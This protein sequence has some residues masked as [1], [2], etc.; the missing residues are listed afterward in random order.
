MRTVNYIKVQ[1]RRFSIGKKYEKDD[2]EGTGHVWIQTGAAHSPP[3]NWQAPAPVSVMSAKIT[4]N[5]RGGKG[6]LTNKR[7]GDGL[8]MK[9]RVR[10]QP[11]SFFNPGSNFRWLIDWLLDCVS[12]V[13]KYLFKVKFL[14]FRFHCSFPLPRNKVT[15]QKTTEKQSVEH[16]K[17][18]RVR[19][20]DSLIFFALTATFQ[21]ALL[22]RI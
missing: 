11:S 20:V 8:P 1:A 2:S 15:K 21:I 18:W 12:F 10:P 3:A 22:R 17:K 9:R 19:T 7:S 5:S 6:K 4:A 13:E 16:L 14:L